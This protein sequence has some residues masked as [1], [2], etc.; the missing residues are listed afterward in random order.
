MPESQL[1]EF[2]ADIVDGGI[3]ERNDANG[4]VLNCDNVGDQVQ[5]GLGLPRTRRSLDN[6]NR[7]GQGFLHCRALTEI[8]AEWKNGGNILGS[9]VD[10]RTVEERI[11]YALWMNESEFFVPKSQVIVAGKPRHD[12]APVAQHTGHRR[13]LS[14]R[15]ND[16]H[17]GSR[18]GRI[19]FPCLRSVE[20]SRPNTVGIGEG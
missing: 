16:P 11:E 1:I 2:V 4:H 12:R 17:P 3:A 9:R 18:V 6:R 14:R 7:T 19:L 8:A 15:G 20:D 10:R 5:D 13:S